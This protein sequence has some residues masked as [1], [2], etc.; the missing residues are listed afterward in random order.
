M[1]IPNHEGRMCD[2]VVRHLEKWTGE[3]RSDIRHPETE[4]VGPPVELRLQLGDQNYAIE[5]TRIEAFDNQIKAGISI[6]EID[7]YIKKWFT[8]PLPGPAYYELQVPLDV[9][10]P[11]KRKERER[12]LSSLG[13]WI[14]ESAHCM[15]GRNTDLFVPVRSKVW[16]EDCVTGS[17]LGAGYEI[18]LLRSTLWPPAFHTEGRNPGTIVLWYNYLD[19]GERNNRH[20]KRLQRAFDKKCPKLKR[21]KEDGA[22]TVLVLEAVGSLLALTDQIGRHLPALLNEREDAPDDIY[23]VSPSDSLW[24]VVPVKHDGDHWPDVGM[25]PPGQSIYEEGKLP[26]AGMPKGYRNALGLDDLY[27]TM[28]RKWLPKTYDHHELVDMIQRQASPRFA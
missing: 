12:L 3:S 8:E 4:G 9:C 11:A 15:Q 19:E 24:W 28:P 7:N 17:L 2:V 20:F 6:R 22:R 23:L 10:L 25:P 1:N 14:Q 5:H 13:D 16:H 26:T 27:V 18:K 21:C